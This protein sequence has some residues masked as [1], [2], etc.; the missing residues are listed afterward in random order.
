[1][2]LAMVRR[3]AERIR[4]F[5]AIPFLLIAAVSLLGAVFRPAPQTTGGGR[6]ARATSRGCSPRPPSSC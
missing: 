6:S 3:K 4:K 1:M 5:S 2:T